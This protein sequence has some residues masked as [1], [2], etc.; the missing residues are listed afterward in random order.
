MP[1]VLPWSHVRHTRL[2]SSGER[3]AN[4]KK[5]GGGRDRRGVEV[6]DV[7]QLSLSPQCGFASTAPGNRIS[8]GCPI[9]KLNP[10][11]FIGGF[12][13]LV[14]QGVELVD[15]AQTFRSVVNDFTEEFA[16]AVADMPA[17][18]EEQDTWL[19]RQ[20][21]TRID[22]DWRLRGT[23]DGNAPRGPSLI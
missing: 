19:Q 7:D 4:R 6:L 18:A 23:T 2:F 21:T 3:N 16:Q 14:G 8:V 1:L 9:S 12:D 5:S 10:H 17:L 15:C 20:S 13:L 11:E 22:G